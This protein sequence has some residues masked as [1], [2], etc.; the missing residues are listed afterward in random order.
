MMLFFYPRDA[1]HHLTGSRRS[2]YEI[3][4]CG[5]SCFYVSLQGA[6]IVN[7]ILNIYC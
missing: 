7:I 5:H 3:E 6:S 4:I 2:L 1:G